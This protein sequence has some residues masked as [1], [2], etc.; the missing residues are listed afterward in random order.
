MRLA[1]PLTTVTLGQ[2]IGASNRC[3]V[4]IIIEFDG[5]IIDIR[6]V[7]YQAHR[8]IATEVGP[9]RP[10]LVRGVVKSLWMA[11]KILGTC[12]REAPELGVRRRRRADR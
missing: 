8:D 5:P 7:Y 1:P 4:R 11:L 9:G 10:R 3:G 2:A 6:R 12:L